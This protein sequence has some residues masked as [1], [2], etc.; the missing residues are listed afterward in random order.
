M[1]WV[2]A[3][4]L[5]QLRTLSS[6]DHIVLP[7]H[8]GQRGHPVVFGRRFWQALAHLQGDQGG[9]HVILDNTDACIPVEVDDSGVL[10]DIDSPTDILGDQHVK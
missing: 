8:Q 9:R 1:P 4:T 5:K 6:T 3:Q 7:F 2:D 10:L